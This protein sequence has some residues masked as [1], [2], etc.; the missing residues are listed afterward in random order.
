MASPVEREFDLEYLGVGVRLPTLADGRGRIAH[1]CPTTRSE[2]MCCMKRVGEGGVSV[3]NTRNGE[4]VVCANNV[5]RALL[6]VR[7]ASRNSPGGHGPDSG[8]PRHQ[9]GRKP[10]GGAVGVCPCGCTLRGELSCRD[11]K[12]VGPTTEAIGEQQYVGVASWS[13]R[14]GAEVVNTDGGT[15]MFR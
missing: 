13:D 6:P 15:W 2:V 1:P 9:C 8:V 14:E 12:D 3:V 7:G 5:V 11:G 4:G 10:S